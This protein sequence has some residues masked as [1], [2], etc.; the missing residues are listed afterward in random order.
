MFEILQ[1][2]TLRSE[3][4][5]EH[6]LAQMGDVVK[7]SN[8]RLCKRTRHRFY[9]SSPNRRTIKHK[10]YFAIRRKN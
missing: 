1:N 8:R 3:E 4:I 9:R 2:K 7:Q 10:I 5:V 6:V